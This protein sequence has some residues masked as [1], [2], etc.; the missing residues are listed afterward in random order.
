MA[1]QLR[2]AFPEE[3]QRLAHRV[4]RLGHRGT[5]GSPKGIVANIW[6]GLLQVRNLARNPSPNS[7]YFFF[8]T[9]LMREN[10]RSLGG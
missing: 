5:T 7:R 1:A 4:G 8:P 6:R 9:P 3:M 2:D 10:S